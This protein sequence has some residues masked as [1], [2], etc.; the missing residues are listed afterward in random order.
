[1]GRLFFL[2]I[3]VAFLTSCS[4]GKKVKTLKQNITESKSL[5]QQ[6]LEG[7][8]KADKARVT[9][10]ENKQLDEATNGK[11]EQYLDSV[12]KVT[13]NHL[14]DDSILLSR[15]IRHKEIYSLTQRIYQLTQEAKANLDNVNMIN[16]LLATNTF[17]QFNT[18]A[19][20]GPGQYVIGSDM[21]EQSSVA[22][23]PVADSILKFAEKFPGKKL[24]ATLVILGYA[25]GQAI[26]P[27]SNLAATLLQKMGK[28]TATSPELNRELSRLRA[29]SVSLLMMKMIRDKA[30]GKPAY[31]GLS[32]NTLPQGR[33][34]EYPNPKISDYQ[35]DDER[36]RVVFVYWSIL[37]NL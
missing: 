36:R 8:E 33:G 27:E 1:M 10:F 29:G 6:V 20:F 12:E 15:K 22:F 34:E 25:D 16:E 21:M 14:M 7:I 2:V 17:T 31:A 26:A 23:G 5:Q 19:F 11:I 37:P 35:Q 3:T 13:K 32:Y 9:K 4:G 18:G 28:E 30:L 24:T